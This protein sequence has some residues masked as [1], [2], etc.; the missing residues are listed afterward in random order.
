MI[1]VRNSDNHKLKWDEICSV[2]PG[3]TIF[4]FQGDSNKF[5]GFSAVLKTATENW[6][7]LKVVIF[8][9][10]QMGDVVMI[11]KKCNDIQAVI[12]CTFPEKQAAA[13]QLIEKNKRRLVQT[14][15]RQEACYYKFKKTIWED[16]LDQY[17]FTNIL[18][19]E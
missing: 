8:L 12:T 16:T 14:V 15:D 11:L 1:V 2:M 3:I 19:V 18:R 4:G 7:K 10:V 9:H 5:F 13:I 6:R 17:D